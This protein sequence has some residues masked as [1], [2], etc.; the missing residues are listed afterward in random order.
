MHAYQFKAYTFKPCI[1]TLFKMLSN[2][3]IITLYILKLLLSILGHAVKK[4]VNTIF[5]TFINFGAKVSL[6]FLFK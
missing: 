3:L 1:V 4:K 6:I 2:D 5:A